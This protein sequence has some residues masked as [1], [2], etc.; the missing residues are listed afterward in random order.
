MYFFG[1]EERPTNKGFN[2]YCFLLM[3][4]IFFVLY[5]IIINY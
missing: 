5:F 1:F 2:W 3:E 4:S